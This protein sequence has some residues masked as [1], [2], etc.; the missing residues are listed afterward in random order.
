MLKA[1]LLMALFSV[2]SERNLCER[3]DYDLMFHFFLDMDMVEP[4]FDATTF[5]Q[6][7]DRLLASDAAHV[8]LKQVVTL[9]RS[10]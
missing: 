8:F 5:S 9:G 7:R 2:A 6:N 10:R 1:Q 3:I 4:T